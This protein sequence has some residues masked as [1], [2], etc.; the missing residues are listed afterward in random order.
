[1]FVTNAKLAKKLKKQYEEINQQIDNLQEQKL[2]LFN[3]SSKMDD[4]CS[5][6]QREML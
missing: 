3:L 4:I 5:T 1:M 2:N 6:S